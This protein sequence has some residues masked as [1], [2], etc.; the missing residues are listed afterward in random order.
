MSKKEGY[1]LTVETKQKDG[2]FKKNYGE[3]IPTPRNL[4]SRY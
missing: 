1:I 3:G 2:E 4:F